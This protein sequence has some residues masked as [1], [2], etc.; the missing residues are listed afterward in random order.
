MPKDWVETCVA[1]RSNMRLSPKSASLR[2]QSTQV[3]LDAIAR[4]K[5]W[6]QAGM[7]AE[8]S[9]AAQRG[10]VPRTAQ[11]GKDKGDGKAC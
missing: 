11:Q 4:A 1:L 6:K 10:K 9:C 8:R 3:C 5:F 2:R 7:A